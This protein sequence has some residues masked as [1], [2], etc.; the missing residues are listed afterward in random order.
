MRAARRWALAAALG[1]AVAVPLSGQ[2]PNELLQRDCDPDVVRV[3]ELTSLPAGW[4]DQHPRAVLARLSDRIAQGEWPAIAGELSHAFRESPVVPQGALRATF[5]AE[6]DSMK[7]Q[8]AAV[9]SSPDFEA[10]VRNADGV[11]QERFRLVRDATIRT[12]CGSDSSIVR[13]ASSSTLDLSLTFGAICA[14]GRSW[15]IGCWS[16][17]ARRAASAPPARS[18]G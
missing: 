16:R 5:Q 18:T 8:F 14:G 4:A 10:L 7:A 9:A 1:A 15:R 2:T 12:S 11:R 17:T 13:R 3:L 6:L